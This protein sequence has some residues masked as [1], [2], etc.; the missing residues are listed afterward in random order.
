MYYNKLTK[1]YIEL[2]DIEEDWSY[3]LALAI[4]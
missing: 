4:S 3:M 1:T 2:L